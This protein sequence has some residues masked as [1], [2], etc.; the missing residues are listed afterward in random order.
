MLQGQPAALLK[1]RLLIDHSTFKVAAFHLNIPVGSIYDFDF[2]T[3]N[4]LVDKVFPSGRW[5]MFQ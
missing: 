1:F 5:W 2:P 3:Q 4:M